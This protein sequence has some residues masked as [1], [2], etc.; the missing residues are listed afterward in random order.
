MSRI[1]LP[2]RMY[3]SLAL[4]WGKEEEEDILRR[5][6]GIQTLYL[7]VIWGIHVLS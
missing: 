2:S 1:V 6:Y 3:S 5:K 4:Q 7:T